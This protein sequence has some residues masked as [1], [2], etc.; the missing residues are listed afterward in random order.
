MRKV[1]LVSTRNS[2]VAVIQYM[3]CNFN[4]VDKYFKLNTYNVNH[5]KSEN[6]ITDTH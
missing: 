2:P 1:R 5:Y 6:T 3:K 4:Y